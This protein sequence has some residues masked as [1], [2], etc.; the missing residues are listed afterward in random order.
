LPLRTRSKFVKALVCKALGYP[1]PESFQKTKSDFTAQ[2]LDVYTQK[3]L[4]VQIWNES[5]DTSRR[6]AFIQVDQNDKILKVKV[7]KGEQ[8]AMFD[9]TG[10]LTTKY[11]AMMP[12][13]ESGQLFSLT[14]TS[15]VQ[16]WCGKEL[17][18][19]ASVNPTSKPIKGLLLPIKTVYKL[20]K[21]IEGIS[22]PQLDALQERNRG[23]LL[24]KLICE[25]LGF[26]TFADTGTYPD[27]KPT[28]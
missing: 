5:V 26:G 17:V 10:T 3:S 24:H 16:E 21:Q 15:S 9:K 11:Q 28:Y 20:L 8:L 23:A 22:I 12:D 25:E 19:L 6:Y 13:L 27:I 14:D 1:V 4:N 2:N 7:I 18:N